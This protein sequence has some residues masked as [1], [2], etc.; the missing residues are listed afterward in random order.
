MFFPLIHYLKKWNL[1]FNCT[2][3]YTCCI[4]VFSWKLKIVMLMVG[5]VIVHNGNLL[6][7]QVNSLMRVEFYS[8]IFRCWWIDICL[9]C[10]YTQK[11]DHHLS[12]THC[13]NLSTCRT[14]LLCAV[15]IFSFVTL[16]YLVHIWLRRLLQGHHLITMCC[17]IY[18]GLKF[19]F[20]TSALKTAV[21]Q[22][23]QFVLRRSRWQCYI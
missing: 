5:G 1:P 10:F 15:F 19:K 11:E 8:H 20:F 14:F 16:I 13:E 22:R 6:S 21:V 4:C 12:S 3:G 2:Q 7:V 17:C 18:S 9:L 23:R